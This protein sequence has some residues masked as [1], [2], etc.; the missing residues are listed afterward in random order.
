MPRVYKQKESVKK[1][2]T[3]LLSRSKLESNNYFIKAMQATDQK[4][5][6]SYN[7]EFKNIDVKVIG[8]CTQFN[9]PVN[10][11]VNKFLN[12]VSV[13][14]RLNPYYIHMVNNYDIIPFWRLDDDNR[15]QADVKSNNYCELNDLNE[16][17]SNWYPTLLKDNNNL[18]YGYF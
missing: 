2:V 18:K 10:I 16:I 9:Y 15:I 7:A 13:Q 5:F 1:K 17:L 6:N 8:K 12:Y 4:A 11:T 3:Y 14:R